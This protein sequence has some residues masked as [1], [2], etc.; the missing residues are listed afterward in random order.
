MN[1]FNCTSRN[2]T[3]LPET[4]QDKTQWLITSHNQFGHIQDVVDYLR[5][6][7]YIDMSSSSIEYISSDVMDA[8]LENT[9]YLNISN[10]SLKVLPETITA[11][12]N[13]TELWISGNPYDCSC[14]VMW[15]RDWL[16]EAT[17]VMDK[18]NVTCN[19]GAM[20]G[21]KQKSCFECIF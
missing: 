3:S 13:Y 4:I 21:E 2:L 11:S 14:D 5:E 10:N 1:I 19:T 7:V 6:I 20:K 18:E 8:L 9:L 16:V 17:H 15:M 12:A